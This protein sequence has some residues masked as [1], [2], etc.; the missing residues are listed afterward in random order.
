MPELL[1]TCDPIYDVLTV[2]ARSGAAL[3]IV[4]R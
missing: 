4:D 3:E 1:L 2:T